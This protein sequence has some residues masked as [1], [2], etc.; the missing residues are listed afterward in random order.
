[1]QPATIGTAGPAGHGKTALVR[2]LSGVRD[3]TTEPEP[4][5]AVIDLGFGYH[6]IGGRRLGVVDLPGTARLVRGLIADAHGIDLVLLVV[7]ADEGVRPQ[8]EECVD[9]LHLLGARELLFVIT[10]T[11]L[12]D[13]ARVAAVRDD[14]ARLAATS[15]FASSPTFAVSSRTGD[16]VPALRDDIL[17]RTANPERSAPEGWFRM[18]V[19]RSFF[20]AGSGLTVTGTAL[21][22]RIRTDD[23]I[24]LRPGPSGGTAARL[25][26]HGETVREARA[27]Q[28]VAVRIA[29]IEKKQ[30][31]RGVVLADPRVEYMTDRCDCWLEVRPSARIALRSFDRVEID[32]GTVETVG[33]VIVLEPGDSLAP[34]ASGFCQI[35]LER[36]MILAHGDRF[37]L[38]PANGVRTTA[39]GVVLHPFAVRHP[40]SET[41]VRDHLARLREPALA[42]RLLAFY[43][44]LPEV[45]APIGYAAQALGRTEEDVARAVAG[46]P[47]LI[48]L[49]SAGTARALATRERW[50]Q[51]IAT[52]TDVLS[53]HHRAHPAEV[54]MEPE[55]LRARLRIPVPPRL[56]DDVVERLVAESVVVRDGEHLRLAAHVPAIAPPPPPS[57]R[58][59][60]SRSAAPLPEDPVARIRRAIAEGGTAPPDWKQLQASLGVTS[61]Q[62][63]SAFARLAGSGEVVLV[64]DDVAFDAD[65]YARARELLVEY[66]TSH[67]EITMAEY[68]TLLGSSRKYAL[69]LLEHF[70]RAGLTVRVGDA[71]RLA[72]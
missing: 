64:A 70:D 2:A 62:L 69:A 25:Q 16:G 30:V 32:V 57:S 6:D 49:P 3:A 21:A 22:G 44:L 19:D 45:A 24:A 13:E 1:M 52:V 18:F 43:E 68:R 26:V 51:L 59:R 58:E 27:G 37:V 61:E 41:G 46:I 9:I 71:R 67:P 31:R 28:R 12:V 53:R 7:A 42:P 66:L 14:V 10:K 56:L 8:T 72:E 20:V 23:S 5:A 38:R 36:E 29:G 35:V 47:E 60:P 40:S 34:G 63:V 4:G 17:A 39:G 48:R 33:S 54:G 50:H 11:D 15:R 65:A 55:A